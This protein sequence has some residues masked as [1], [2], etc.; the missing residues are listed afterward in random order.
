MSG[1]GT[2]LSESVAAAVE[3]AG[4]AVVRVEAR[5]RGTSSGVVW[6]ADGLIVA[7]HHNV[8]WDEDIPIGLPDGTSVRAKVVGRDPGTDL[9]LLRAP[10]E[11]AAPPEWKTEAVKVGHLVLALTRPGRTVRASLGVV[12]AQGDEWRTGGGGRIDRYL[13]TDLPLQPAFSGSLLVDLQGR[14]LAVNNAGLM[15]GASLAVPPATVR[16]VVESLLA[17]GRVRRGFLGISTIPVRPPAGVQASA[18]QAAVLLVTS[19]QEDS[20]AGK[21]GLLLGDALVSVE[22]QAVA[23]PGDLVPFLEEDGIGRPLA[24]RILRAGRLEEVAVKVGTREEA[25]GRA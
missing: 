23:S 8:E 10:F 9:A 1:I 24:L 19:V 22:G 13:E 18:G 25:G 21:A 12:H 16:R 7:A 20:G 4:R 6:S 2:D 17:H 5:R 3:T 14:A 11:G 15:R